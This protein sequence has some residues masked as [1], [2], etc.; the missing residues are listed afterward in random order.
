MCD[1]WSM[2]MLLPVGPML[3]YRQEVIFPVLCLSIRQ[4]HDAIRHGACLS[5]IQKANDAGVYDTY[6]PLVAGLKEFHVLEVGGRKLGCIG[7]VEEDWLETLFG[8]HTE[9][10]PNL[11]II[12]GPQ[13]GGGARCGCREPLDARPS[14][15][16]RL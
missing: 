3:F 2:D 11:L 16:G 9:D 1:G 6:D 4:A 7:L 12:M 5:N 14:T 13:G 15:G 10:F 8:I